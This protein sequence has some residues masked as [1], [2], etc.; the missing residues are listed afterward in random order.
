V[1][2][3]QLATDLS[4][5][6]LPAFAMVVPNALDDAHSCPDQTTTTCTV[7]QRLA[8]ADTWMRN[9]IDPLLSNPQFQQS[10]VLAVTF[11]ESRDDNTNIGG[12]VFTVVVGAGV[13][14][15]YVATGT[16]Q[17]QSMLRTILQLLG[18]NSFPG[19]AANAPAMT[20]IFQQ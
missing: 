10:G 3:S 17:H 11:D 5:G 15:K 1:P 8:T 19:D 9:N 6:N 2:F 18:A 7:A 14:Q 13:K 4:S 12:Q 20:E 16:Y